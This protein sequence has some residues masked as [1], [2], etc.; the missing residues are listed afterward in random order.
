ML[1][2][3]LCSRHQIGDLRKYVLISRYDFKTMIREQKYPLGGAEMKKGMATT[4]LT[5][6]LIANAGQITSAADLDPTLSQC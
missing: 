3:L 1:Q 6:S 2:L 4:A 5:L